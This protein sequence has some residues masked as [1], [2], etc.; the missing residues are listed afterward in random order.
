MAIADSSAA[1]FEEVHPD[2]HS[3][4]DK[5]PQPYRRVEKIVAEIIHTT[6]V[7]IGERERIRAELAAKQ[8]PTVWT[9][10][11][12]T[13]N[14]HYIHLL[15]SSLERCLTEMWSVSPNPADAEGV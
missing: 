4:L 14:A 12:F 10:I 8:K 11:Q 6:L 7:E 15:G 1:A 2:P 3:R 5:L 9:A 13:R